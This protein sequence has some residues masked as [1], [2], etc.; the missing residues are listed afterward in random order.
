MI[1]PQCKAK[2]FKT[3]SVLDDAGDVERVTCANESCGYI[4]SEELVV[5]AADGSKR[6]RPRHVKAE[7]QPEGFAFTGSST[8]ASKPESD[9]LL[10]AE[11]M[12]LLAL[13]TQEETV[14]K[15][16]KEIAKE[17]LSECA[18]NVL[19][20]EHTY[21]IE[22]ENSPPG[23]VIVQV[24][25]ELKDRGYKVKKTPSPGKGTEIHVKWPT[26]RPQKKQKKKSPV[27]QDAP[28]V[29]ET[30]ELTPKQQRQMEERAKRK[31]ALKAR[32]K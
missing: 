26:K 30:K 10:T 11:A 8:A 6:K 13:Q 28:T 16:A 1:C 27:A 12:M 2:E 17:I 7:D 23:A 14:G 5:E 22:E 3:S 21:V 29:V 4:V 20:G 15:Q 9:G 24:V 31:A 19:N 18:E 32:S 25:Q